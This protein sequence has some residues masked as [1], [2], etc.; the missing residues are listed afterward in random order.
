V[1]AR[2]RGVRELRRRSRA[3]RRLH[4]PRILPWFDRVFS[5]RR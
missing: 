5:G 2:R 4:R 1:R 3:A